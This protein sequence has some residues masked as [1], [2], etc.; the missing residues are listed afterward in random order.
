MPTPRRYPTAAARQAAYRA[1]LA[2]AREQELAAKRLPALPAVPTLPGHARW[3]A[4]LQQAALLLRTTQEEMQA[5]Y[6]QRSD[7]WQECGRGEAF[8]ER[9][10]RLQ[11]V[12]EA[13]EELWG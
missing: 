11:E 7:S 2:Q 4:L 3:T 10:E 8:L 1:R 5:Y 13:A 6:D 9:L 12:Q